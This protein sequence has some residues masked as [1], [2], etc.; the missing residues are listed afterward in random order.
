[1]ESIAEVALEHAPGGPIEV[2]GYGSTPTIME[3]FGDRL[4]IAPIEE[5]K[6]SAG[7]LI[8]P[9]TAQEKPQ[10]GRVVAAGPKCK[11]ARADQTVLY[12][13]YAGVEIDINRTTYIVLR[14]DDVMMALW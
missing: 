2:P 12:T 10:T 3:P 7:G 11:Q 5:E 14:E 4:I 6:V 8:V 13:R 9:E 1:M